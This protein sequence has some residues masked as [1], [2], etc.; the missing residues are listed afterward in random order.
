VGGNFRSGPESEGRFQERT[1]VGLVEE[2]RQAIKTDKHNDKKIS[3]CQSMSLYLLLS[4][5]FIVSKP[6]MQLFD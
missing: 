2:R 4:I 1:G 3:W 5:A 6:K